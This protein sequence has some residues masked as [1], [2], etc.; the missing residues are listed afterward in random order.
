MSHCW[1]CALPTSSPILLW[2]SAATRG[3]W[4]KLSPCDGMDDARCNAHS[5][6][7]RNSSWA[8]PHGADVVV[9]GCSVWEIVM[10]KGPVRILKSN[11]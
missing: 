7:G 2:V 8:A 3:G 11:F 4:C 9:Y 10:D 5:L 6:T 1:V